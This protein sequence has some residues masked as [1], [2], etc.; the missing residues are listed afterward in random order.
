MAIFPCNGCICYA[1]C[2]SKANEILND[3]I[4]SYAEVLISLYDRC[5]LIKSF[6]DNHNIGVSTRHLRFL[7]GNK[8]NSIPL[9]L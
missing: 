7:Y 4:D 9:P 6:V 2:N 3:H 5:E 8:T 1:I